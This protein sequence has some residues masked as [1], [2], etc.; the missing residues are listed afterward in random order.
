MAIF[1]LF[2]VLHYFPFGIQLT[3]SIPT[4][5]QKQTT[6]TSQVLLYHL[7]PIQIS[8]MAFLN[9]DSHSILFHG[10]QMI[11]KTRLLECLEWLMVYSSLSYQN[12]QFSLLFVMR[13]VEH[14]ILARLHC[15]SS[16]AIFILNLFACHL[17][18]ECYV[19][20]HIS[21]I[22]ILGSLAIQ[23]LHHFLRSF[24]WILFQIE[25]IF[26]FINQHLLLQV[27]ILCSPFFS[28][29]S[30]RPYPGQIQV[31]N[32]EIDLVMIFRKPIGFKNLNLIWI[33]Y[34]M[35]YLMMQYL[36]NFLGSDYF[37]LYL[38]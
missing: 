7:Q 22:F 24:H 20:H 2:V 13:K 23:H 18:Y 15:C 11:L 35:I 6:V 25:L 10:I 3:F 9:I 37:K 14:F 1:I 12:F 31:E 16:L 26:P 5:N 34:L 28:L 21:F 4:L 8:P 30:L 29:T 27:M 32:F 17:L 36:P 33:L 19:S 38:I